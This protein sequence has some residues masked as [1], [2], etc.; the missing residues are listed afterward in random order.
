MQQQIHGAALIARM[1]N[2]PNPIRYVIYDIIRLCREYGGT[3]YQSGNRFTLAHA[4]VSRSCGATY[5]GLIE[6]KNVFRG[7]R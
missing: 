1:E 5:D 4:G 2:K 7:V 6:L 3:L